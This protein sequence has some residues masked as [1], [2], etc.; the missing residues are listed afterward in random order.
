MICGCWMCWITSPLYLLDYLITRTQPHTQSHTTIILSFTRSVFCK[1]SLL[2]VLFLTF[3][4][5]K[6]WQKRMKKGKRRVSVFSLK[7]EFHGYTFESYSTNYKSLTLYSRIECCAFVIEIIITTTIVSGFFFVFFVSDVFIC[8]RFAVPMNE[9]EI[10]SLW[11]GPKKK[12]EK[13]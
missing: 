11:G 13:E 5:R 9:N 7:R 10:E 8:C 12:R 3:A 1:I 2:F 6:R 4:R